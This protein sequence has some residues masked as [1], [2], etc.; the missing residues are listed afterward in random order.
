MTVFQSSMQ[1]SWSPCV[2]SPLSGYCS[3]GRFATLLSRAGLFP[4]ERTSVSVQKRS[5]VVVIFGGMTRRILTWNGGLTVPIQITPR[6]SLQEELLVQHACFPL[7]TEP[8]V[9]L[10]DTWPWRK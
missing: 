8:A 2:S 3:G 4:E 1:W 7:D 9:V 5:I 10:E 6:K